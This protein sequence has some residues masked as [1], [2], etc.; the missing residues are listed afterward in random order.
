MLHAH[1]YHKQERAAQF[2]VYIRMTLLI[3][4]SFDRDTLQLHITAKIDETSCL[5]KSLFKLGLQRWQATNIHSA[6]FHQ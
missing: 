5:L 3:I 6:L 2:A 4:T 1:V